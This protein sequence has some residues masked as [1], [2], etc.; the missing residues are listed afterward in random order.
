MIG[1]IILEGPDGAGKTTLADKLAKHFGLPVMHLTGIKDQDKLARQFRV[2]DNVVEVILDRFVVSNIAYSRIFNATR[3]PDKAL[4]GM[5]RY[6]L[7]RNNC[8]LNI[9]CLPGYMSGDSASYKL[10]YEELMKR[11]S[12]E[13]T[14]VDKME[15]MWL[16]MSTVYDIMRPLCNA[17]VFDYMNQTADD[18]IREIEDTYYATHTEN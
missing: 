13:F 7:E 6:T 8:D 9:F 10:A 17:V 12:E 15:K 1:R 14:D 3:L 16:Y 4:D 2:A 5:F 18:F 11:R